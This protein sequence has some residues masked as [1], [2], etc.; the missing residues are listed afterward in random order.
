MLTGRLKPEP[1]HV[2]LQA[3]LGVA[4]PQRVVVVI[5]ADLA[6]TH[7]AD[8]PY[9]FSP[10]AEPFD[11]AVRAWAA[12]QGRGRGREELLEQVRAD[13]AEAPC[14]WGGCVLCTASLH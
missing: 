6:H 5:S 2:C 13:A 1:C 7:S 9:G 3:E 10:H 11:R 12:G 4:E 8:G 14:V